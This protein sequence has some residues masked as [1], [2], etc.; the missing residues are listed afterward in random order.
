[1][2]PKEFCQGYLSNAFIFMKFIQKY[3]YLIYVQYACIQHVVTF[4]DMFET[5]VQPDQLGLAPP[6]VTRTDG[7]PLVKTWS[8][9][10]QPRWEGDLGDPFEPYQVLTVSLVAKLRF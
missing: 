2:E 6:G 10:W 4:V 9:G 3:T 5:I 7:K 1:L 8:E